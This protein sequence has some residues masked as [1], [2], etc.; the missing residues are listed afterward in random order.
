MNVELSPRGDRF[1]EGVGDAGGFGG[2]R[3]IRVWVVAA[4]AAGA[5]RAVADP[6]GR[7]DELA[8]HH[9]GQGRHGPVR[10]SAEVVLGGDGRRVVR[11]ELRDT[12]APD[13]PAGRLMAVAHVGVCV[14]EQQV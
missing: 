4:I 10:T 12:G 13:E 11:V 2:R 8:V 5:A 3:A 7:V 6:A 14:G 9:L 1:E